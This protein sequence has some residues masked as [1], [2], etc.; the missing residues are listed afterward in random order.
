MIPRG[1]R[2]AMLAAIFA[3]AALAGCQRGPAVD[4]V[5]PDGQLRARVSIE[6]AD[7]PAAR[8]TGLMYRNHLDESSGMLFVFH[9]PDVL[10]FWMKNTE[11]PLDMIFADADRRVVWIVAKAEPYSTH[12]VGP[13]TASQ[14]VLEVNGG[15]AEDHGVEVGDHLDFLRFTP[16]ARD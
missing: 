14:Y 4:I 10:S 15:F 8:E 12:P 9:T 2:I 13:A 1:A 11:L 5:G 16:H 3:A 6:I 7:T